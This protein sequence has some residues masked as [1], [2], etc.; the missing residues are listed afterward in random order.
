MRNCGIYKITC[1]NNEFYYIGQSCQIIKR[2]WRHKN[3]LKNNNHDNIML[4]RCFNKY[5]ETSLC[6]EIIEDCE[7]E[8][9]DSSEQR[10][11][12]LSATDNLCININRTATKPPDPT[13]RI[14]SDET[15]NKISKA[16]LGKKRSNDFKQQV[17]KMHQGNQ[18]WL[19][20]THTELSKKKISDAN[21][22]KT[23]WLGKEHT[24]STKKKISDAN[25]NQI[26]WNKGIPRTE[27]EKKKI[28]N[29]KKGKTS[30][31]LG[32]THTESAKRK[33]S[34]R[35]TLTI[36]CLVSPEGVRHTFTKT[37]EFCK[38][39]GLH[40]KYVYELLG[41]K[42]SSYKQWKNPNHH[43]L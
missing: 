18:Y 40:A 1:V 2:F 36:H 32:K 17:S 31:M 30:G 42:I 37:K 29:S 9:L 26:P 38:E 22:G 41:G 43:C 13:G 12:D 35:Q 8:E 15:K 34:D 3:D 39:H 21:K 28:S 27:E 24:D 7:P 6:F 4:Q 14:L 11:L 10:W 20:K 33:M 16:N 19:G 23:P 5:G 25:K